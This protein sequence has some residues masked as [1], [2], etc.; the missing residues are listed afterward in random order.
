MSRNYPQVFLS[1]LLYC[2]F[3]QL[4]KNWYS[5]IE[6]PGT[7]ELLESW[8]FYLLKKCHCRSKSLCKNILWSL[9]RFQENTYNSCCSLSFLYAI[10]VLSFSIRHMEGKFCT[11]N[12]LPSSPWARG[13]VLIAPPLLP[14]NIV[15]EVGLQ[16]KPWEQELYFHFCSW[17]HAVESCVWSTAVNR[18]RSIQA[19]VC[20]EL[21]GCSYCKKCLLK[22]EGQ[23]L[24]KG[25]PH[26]VWWHW[27]ANCLSGLSW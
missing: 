14:L 20:P 23:L 1:F 6:T 25:V 9:Q 8:M 5:V 26:R 16:I 12:S 22:K 3:Q 19:T 10:A 27:Q 7:T 11:W 13:D 4:L 17:S 2:I 21:P 18:D 24:V 15:N